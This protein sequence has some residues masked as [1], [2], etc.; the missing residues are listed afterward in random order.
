MK[1][2]VLFAACLLS[3]GSCSNVLLSKLMLL[4]SG[5]LLYT[6]NIVENTISGFTLNEISGQLVV[7]PDGPFSAGIH[8]AS[9][10]VASK[11]FVYCVNEGDASISRVSDRHRNRRPCAAD[12]LPGGS[13]SEPRHC[14]R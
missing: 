4:R 1:P 13:R 5:D 11:R 6:A 2:L 12:G 8:P 9:L 3:L 7:L 10:A 14:H